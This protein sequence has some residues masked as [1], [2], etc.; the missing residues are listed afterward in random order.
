MMIIDQTIREQ[1][2]DLS[3]SYL[4]QA[5]AGSGKTELLTQRYLALL[6]HV[7][8]PEEILAITFTRKAAAEMRSRV[9]DVLNQAAMK[10][11]E[12]K[13][14]TE[15]TLQLAWQVLKQDQAHS[16]NLL[17]SPHRLRLMTFDAFLLEIV[18][19]TPILSRLGSEPHITEYPDVYYRQTA[20]ALLDQLDETSAW[21]NAL[22]TLLVHLN[23]RTDLFESLLVDM[24][25]KRDQWIPHL[26]Q[27]KNQDQL[28]TLLE[29]G[30]AISL[31]ET[32]KKIIRFFP[33]D[34]MGEFIELLSF[35]VDHLDS[36][37]F[38]EAVNLRSLKTLPSSESTSREI[39][40]ALSH[41]LLTQENKWRKSVN[42]SIG[43]PPKE[44]A[45]DKETKK[46]YV[47]MKARMESLLSRLSPCSLLLES[48]QELQWLP[49]PRYTDKQWKVVTAM[50]EILPVAAAQLSLILREAGK[51]DFIE[52]TLAAFNA[53]GTEDCP[54]S[55]SLY[56]DYSLQHILIDE[57]QD[58]SQLQSVFLKLLIAEWQP[59]DGK[60]L[61]MVGDPMQ[62]IYRFRNAD[63]GLFLRA[64]Q[65]GIGLVPLIPL[66]LSTNFRARKDIVDWINQLFPR[67][68]PSSENISRGAVTYTPASAVHGH[69][70]NAV[71]IHPLMASPGQETGEGYLIAQL[72]REN[73]QTHPQETIAIL[74]RSRTHLSAILPI[75]RQQKI[76]YYAV[77]LD[78]LA[79][80]MIIQD[81]FSLTRA[82]LHLSDR[83]AW[84]SVLRAPWCGLT[85]ADLY[86]LAGERTKDT[87][88]WDRLKDKQVFQSLSHS[89]QR[90]LLFILPI[91][92]A[93]LEERG[94]ISVR[95]LVEKVWR[96]LY[97]PSVAEKDND[98]IDA[99]NY[100]EL[101]EELD[102]GGD[103]GDMRILKERLDSLFASPDQN[104]DATIQVMTIHK[105]KG[106]EFD[107]VILPGL[108]RKINQPDKPLLSWLERLRE[109][110]D[111]DLLLAPIHVS[112]KERDA[113]YTYLQ[114]ENKLKNDYET[115]RLFYVAATRAKRQLHL[116]G[117]VDSLDTLEK[118]TYDKNC[119][120][121]YFWPEFVVAYQAKKESVSAKIETRAEVSVVP[122]LR[123]IADDFFEAQPF[124]L[125]GDFF[126]EP[127]RRV[128]P[129]ALLSTQRSLFEVPFQQAV[130][131]ETLL[132]QTQEPHPQNRYQFIGTLVHM[133]LASMAREGIAQFS[134]ERLKNNRHSWRYFLMEQ[135]LS[136]PRAEEASLT[137]YETLKRARD[138]ARC[139][140]ILKPRPVAYSEYAL[141]FVQKDL[142]V[143]SVILDR[144]FIDEDDQ[145]LWI[146]DFKTSQ[147]SHQLWDDFIR[148]EQEK[149]RQQLETYAQ[150]ASRL[151]DS[152]LAIRLGL[153]FPC[154]PG[155]TEWNY[156]S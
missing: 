110:Q 115:Q 143:Q 95:A 146:I 120:L 26:V 8:L 151:F 127:T 10:E 152:Q 53:L 82:L 28:K 80:R 45:K 109:N 37:V 40:L 118:P 86:V 93:A 90:R 51:A 63:V 101:L 141:S 83:V 16:W 98:V 23:N 125:P 102:T 123:R 69:E 50:L 56:F 156:F 112:E 36:S 114:H 39:W 66:S 13:N 49:E 97:G 78:T 113:I 22:V 147:P 73:K 6:A 42:K 7:R 132:L 85:L 34:L 61:F 105:A 20:Q 52:V 55:L 117:T 71:V 47:A 76:P 14:H 144:L 60:T 43:F 77:E 1:A 142:T 3:H 19:K 25:K 91:L 54:S 59:G 124:T 149:Y 15:K 122:S 33:A 135:G 62:S 21:R 100:F 148:S 9:M 38:P 44:S 130:S 126:H 27:A 128:N 68:F 119:F 5:P 30:L 48:L 70:P 116:I 17:K 96:Q 18:Q 99:E 58:T 74:V 94:R 64:K 139:Q 41:F 104:A 150:A 153:Y 67:L 140:W 31:E 137:V 87:I 121:A 11:G 89:A 24:L 57:F 46:L 4:V 103:V 111:S 145:S 65:Y 133:L 136:S 29:R 2:L 134:D 107:T 35:A 129:S 106:L 79:H 92:N 131:S 12:Y 72:I 108:E 88:L 32:L 154:V 155:W 75:L 138:D 81:L 84:L